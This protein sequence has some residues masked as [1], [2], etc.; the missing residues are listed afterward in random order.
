MAKKKDNKD[1]I[2]EMVVNGWNASWN[3]TSGAYH[4]KWQK[5]SDLYDSIRV[6]V[7]Y[8]GISDTFV[9]M[10]FS[11]VETM[12]SATSGEKPVVEYIQ[13]SPEQATNVEVLNGLF[14]YYWDIDNWTNKK[15]ASRYLC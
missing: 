13:T 2:V 8:N 15:V 3:Y 12:V 4:H 11:T 6:H 1:T 14:S 10:S 9:P 7:G 5:W